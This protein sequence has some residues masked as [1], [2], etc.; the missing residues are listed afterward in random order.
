MVDSSNRFVD[1][2]LPMAGG[3]PIP[4]EQDI[5]C[6]ELKIVYYGN[7]GPFQSPAGVEF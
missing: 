6:V 2:A 1:V 7:S 4:L 5:K 3:V